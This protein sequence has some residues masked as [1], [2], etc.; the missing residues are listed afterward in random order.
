[1]FDATRRWDEGTGRLAVGTISVVVAI[2]LKYFG[3]DILIPVQPVLWAAAGMLA[4]IA[5]GTSLNVLIRVVFGIA[6]VAALLA[7]FNLERIFGQAAVI[8]FAFALAPFGGWLFLW[9]LALT[10]K[11]K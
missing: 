11:K 9:G 10:T 5:Y 8:D 4:F 3:Y 7:S 1:M 6:A 2:A